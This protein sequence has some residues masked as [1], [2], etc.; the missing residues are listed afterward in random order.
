MK[1]PQEYTDRMKKL[2]ADL[3]S[4]EFDKYIESLERER[5]YGLRVNRL[6]LT[7]DEWEEIS[8]FDITLGQKTD[9]ITKTAIPEDIHFTIVAF[10]IYKNQVQCIRALV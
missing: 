3:G 7:T 6:K 2:L 8:P 1:L 9:I 10:T 4:D 5:F